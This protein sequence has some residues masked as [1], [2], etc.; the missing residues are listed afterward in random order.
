VVTLIPA[1]QRENVEERA[2][3]MEN[4]GRLSGDKANR[5]ALSEYL[6]FGK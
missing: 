4:E 6:S 5:A 2:A 1:D 3:I